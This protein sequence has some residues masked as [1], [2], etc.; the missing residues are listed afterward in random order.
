MMPLA[1]FMAA[2]DA[3]G[4]KKIELFLAEPHSTLLAIPLQ[5]NYDAP[6]PP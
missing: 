1:K 6:P 5:S 2:A 3:A 4:R